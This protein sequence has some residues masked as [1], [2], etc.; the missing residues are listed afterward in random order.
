MGLIYM[1]TNKVNGKS[2]IGLTTGSLENRCK[3][4]K[5]Q[6]K[7]VDGLFQRAINKY[8]WDN[9][10]WEVLE[11]DIDSIDDLNKRE[12]Y[13]IDKYDTF[14]NGYNMTLGGMSPSIIGENHP[15][16]LYGDELWINIK[17]ELIKTDESLH[18]IAEKYGVSIHALRHFSSMRV[19]QYIW[20]DDYNPRLNRKLTVGMELLE[21]IYVD[22]VIKGKVIS[23][24]SREYGIGIRIIRDFLNR[25][26]H[27][28]EY[29]Y[30]DKK[31][32][33]VT[34]KDIQSP[35]KPRKVTYDIMEK[36]YLEYHTTY[37]TYSLLSKKYELSST[38][39]RDFLNGNIGYTLD[40]I[41]EYKHK[42][43]YFLENN[44][45]KNIF[46]NIFKEFFVDDKSY[47]EIYNTLN[48]ERY[49]ISMSTVRM[50]CNR[51]L[52]LKIEWYDEFH[53]KYCSQIKKEDKYHVREF[54][55][56]DC[57]KIYVKYYL[58]E[59]SVRKIS[60]QLGDVFTEIRIW[61][62]LKGKNKYQTNWLKEFED[63]YGKG[64]R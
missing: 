63:K 54:T 60:I 57:E 36:V 3:Q 20:G 51:D 19:K 22:R 4:H 50:F 48:L 24:I 58:E 13:Y 18:L 37:T 39:I 17:K 53:T 26:T 49:N 40:W 21:N 9:F 35:F 11:D 10:S 43:K 33:K 55:K 12:V 16:N 14:N 46:E 44:S 42:N 32:K 31:Y 8:G 25:K 6:A 29:L 2:Y 41:E 15:R 7:R 52:K 59:L 34:K 61:R 28:D 64:V 47:K 45:L 1:A 27:K 38:T 5:S 23:D 62:F 30:L 56:D